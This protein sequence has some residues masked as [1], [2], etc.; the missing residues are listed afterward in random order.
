MMHKLLESEGYISKE[1]KLIS[2]MIT[3]LKNLRKN[4]LDS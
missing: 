3:E 4:Y 1:I 2:L